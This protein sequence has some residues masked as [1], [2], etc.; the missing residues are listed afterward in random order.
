[1]PRPRVAERIERDDDGESARTRRIPRDNDVDLS[2]TGIAGLESRLS[3]GENNL[4]SAC[5]EQPDLL[6]SVVKEVAL[7]RSRRDGKKKELEESEAALYV[8]LRHDAS[9]AAERVTEGEIKANITID[10]T[11]KRLNDELLASNTQLAQWEALST[12]YSQRSYMLR[13]LCA[14]WLA[15][16]YGGDV[17]G[18]AERRAAGNIATARLHEARADRSRGHDQE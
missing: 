16:H 11:I 14:L 2:P 5:N 7:A 12:A 8:R 4:E 9:V 18:G 1:M 6:Y 13:E 3:I 17:V 15:R 10:T